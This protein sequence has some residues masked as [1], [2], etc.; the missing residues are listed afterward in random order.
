[1]LDDLT[2]LRAV[3]RDSPA[4]REILKNSAVRRSKQREIFASFAPT[5]YHKITQNYLDTLIEGGR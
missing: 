3:L 1:M 4:F 5:N 2:H